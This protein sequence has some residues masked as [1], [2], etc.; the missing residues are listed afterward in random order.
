MLNWIDRFLKHAGTCNLSVDDPATTILRKGI[1]RKNR[2]LFLLYCEWY[3]ML[4]SS[5]VESRD[6]LELGSGGGFFDEYLPRVITSDIFELPGVQLI[7]DAQCLPLPQRSLDAIVMTNVFHH[8]SDVD[9]FFRE[10]T[11]CL[12]PG[13]RLVMIEPWRTAWSERIYKTLHSEPFE[14]ES[15]WGVSGSGPLSCANGALPWI[16]FYRDREIFERNYPALRVIKV[17][18]IMPFSY[19]LSGGVSRRGVIPGWAYQ[20]IRLCERALFE[21]F[22][23]MFSLIIVEKKR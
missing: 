12:R 13:G 1:I 11:R 19:I 20:P 10:A 2:F 3:R 23:A 7:V 21:R 8:I 15:G 18:P 6:V 17:R 16:V 5:L 9:L 22:W 4:I 14:S